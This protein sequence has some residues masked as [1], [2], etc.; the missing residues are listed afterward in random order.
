MRDDIH[1]LQAKC[2]LFDVHNIKTRVDWGQA[3]GDI[4]SLA[5][6][7]EYGGVTTHCAVNSKFKPM[8]DWSEL[9]TRESSSDCIQILCDK[10]W[11]SS[12]GCCLLCAALPQMKGTYDACLDVPGSIT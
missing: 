2:T 4:C 8:A 11:Q 6:S 10:S 12:R 5:N 3:S 1:L 7:A 9:G